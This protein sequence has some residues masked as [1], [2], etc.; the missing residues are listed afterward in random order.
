M[1]SKRLIW[2]LAGMVMLMAIAGFVV[3]SSTGPIAAKPPN[4]AQ[5]AQGIMVNLIGG[6]DYSFTET[7]TYKFNKTTS[8]TYFTNAWD[9]N[10]PT[11]TSHTTGGNFCTPPPPATKPPA[12]LPDDTQLNSGNPGKNDVTGK[13]EC[14]FLDGTNLTG[15]SYTQNCKHYHVLHFW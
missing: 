10:D 6:G 7:D 2:M 15:G 13:N 8:A 12:P 3:F 1:K 14:Q 4:A 11:V 5:T 9:G